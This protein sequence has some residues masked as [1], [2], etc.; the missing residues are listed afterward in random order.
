MK[1]NTLAYL[2]IAS[3]AIS[4]NFCFLGLLHYFNIY[5]Q[6]QSISRMMLN[7]FYL[8]FVILFFS[9]I[10]YLIF[11]MEK[12]IRCFKE[13]QDCNETLQVLQKGIVKLPTYILGLNMLYSIIGPQFMLMGNAVES[14]N[15]MDLTFLSLAVL[16]LTGI[17]FYIFFIRSFEEFCSIVPF[18]SEYLSMKLATRT[19]LVTLFSLFSLSVLVFL[20]IK[21]SA[22]RIHLDLESRNAIIQVAAPLLIFGIIMTLVCIYLLMAGINKRILLGQRMIEELSRGDYTH[23]DVPVPS[24]DELG[25][26][27]HEINL[28]RNI[29]GSAMRD[30]NQRA[31]KTIETKQNLIT[32]AEESSSAM[33]EMTS[34]IQSVGNSI[35]NLDNNIQDVTQSMERLNQFIGNLSANMTEQ[36]SGQEESTA[37]I[38]EMTASIDNI[39]QIAQ[40]KIQASQELQKISDRGENV[41][42]TTIDQIGK[43]FDSLDRIKDM[44]KLILNI[45]SQTNLLAM[46]AAIE[47]AH[48]GE[49]GRGFSVVADEIRKLAETSSVNSKQ[50]NQSIQEIVALVES[51]TESGGKTTQAFGAIS[52]GI[53]DTLDSLGEI[54]TGMSELKAGGGQILT[55]VDRIRESS[56]TLNKQSEVMLSETERV[57]KA[58][59][60]LT[61][62]SAESRV[63]MDE[64]AIGAQE[65]LDS[66]LSLNDQAA[67]LDETS[68][69]LQESINR[70]KLAE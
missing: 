9:I 13:K 64:M 32:V 33:T 21:A 22:Q 35:T 62:I 24:R 10:F 51:A 69:G 26:L 28:V 50:I 5:N 27:I 52:Q 40:G 12:K 48:A 47:A 29:T 65:V 19:L 8:G 56:E 61:Q 46:N 44:T 70:F 54:S 20:S 66:S 23:E 55:S 2:M 41:L 1:K 58:A 7:P 37:A 18:S 39:T 4:Y 11:S 17:P 59:A 45:A 67:E 14:G 38:E 3:I 16:L 36:V 30:I 63:A 57:N 31:S 15:R 34:N 25:E 68:R 53:R 49:A 60:G 42:K 43:I 6:N